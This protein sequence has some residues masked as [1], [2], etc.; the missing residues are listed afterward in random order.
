MIKHR[1]PFNQVPIC[2]YHKSPFF[3]S[4]HRIFLFFLSMYL[5]DTVC[6]SNICTWSTRNY[7]CRSENV[8]EDRVAFLTIM[9][10]CAIENSLPIHNYTN[11]YNQT[12]SI[13]IKCSCIEKF[14][15]II[16]SLEEN[17]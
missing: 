12:T 1:C 3:F 14:N 13:S 5:L 4:H 8:Y 15:F 16:D 2:I 10:R 7:V 17:R 6:T 11:N 9:C